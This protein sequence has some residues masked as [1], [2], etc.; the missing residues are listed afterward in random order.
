MG[1]KG[2]PPPSADGEAPAPPVPKPQ[3]KTIKCVR[4]VNISL[5]DS[6]IRHMKVQP[7]VK[8]FATIKAG[9]LLKLKRSLLTLNETNLISCDYADCGNLN[10]LSLSAENATNSYLA[11]TTQGS[12]QPFNK[13][14]LTLHYMEYFGT[15]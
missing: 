11:K 5:R 13:S 9:K 2:P 3:P 7:K 10:I 15:D 8:V 6:S 1:K 14:A 12:F 4:K